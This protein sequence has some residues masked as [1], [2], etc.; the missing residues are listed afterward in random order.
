MHFRLFR[1]MTFVFM[2][3][4]AVIAGLFLLFLFLRFVESADIASGEVYVF[5]LSLFS[6]VFVQREGLLTFAV[7]FDDLLGTLG[8]DG[9][10][11]RRQVLVCRVGHETCQDIALEEV[12]V[13]ILCLQDDVLAR[14]VFACFHIVVYLIVQTALQL[15]AHACQFL[16]IQRDILE[17]QSSRPQGPV[18]PMRPAS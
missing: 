11:V 13:G 1:S 14:Q 16:G 9:L 18:P 7:H 5:C 12:I 4:L 10:E 3:V 6:T 2:V 8:R 17:Q 15:S